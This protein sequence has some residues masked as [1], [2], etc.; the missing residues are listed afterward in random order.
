MKRGVRS[1]PHDA[2]IKVLTSMADDPP[3]PT[4]DAD[5]LAVLVGP[6]ATGRMALA[7]AQGLGAPAT[8][9]ATLG[10]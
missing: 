6:S 5:A 10:D 7:E 4:N 8:L 2:P 9:R 3:A 1:G